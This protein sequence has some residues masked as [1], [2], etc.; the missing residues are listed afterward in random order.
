MSK[1]IDGAQIMLQAETWHGLKLATGN[2]GRLAI[3]A[4][5][6]AETIESAAQILELDDEPA[7]FTALL[8]RSA[9][10]QDEK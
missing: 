4:R 6:F 1:K 8:D 10:E 2:A 7:D 3:E 5:T 9:A